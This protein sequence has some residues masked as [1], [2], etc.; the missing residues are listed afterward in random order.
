MAGIFSASDVLTA[1]QEIEQRG[2]VFYTRLAETATDPSL[3]QTFR[4]LAQEEE[5]HWQI[6]HDL[7]DRLGE[8]EL[9]AWATEEE[10]VEYLTALIDSHTLFRLGDM[11]ALRQFV[12]SREEAIHAAMGFEKDTIVFFKEMQ[13]FV[14]EG[15]RGAVQACVEEERRHLRMLAGL[16]R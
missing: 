2:Q 12:G 4:F 9:P 1:A 5:K 14:P 16:L 13:D 11:D 8:V 15:D 6:F 10:Y 7:A 3:A